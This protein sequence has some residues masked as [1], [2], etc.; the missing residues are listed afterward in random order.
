MWLIRKSF[1]LLCAFCAASLADDSTTKKKHSEAAATV[2]SAASATVWT[3]PTD[4]ESRNLLYG[5]GGKKRAPQGTMFTFEKEDLNGTNPKFDVRDDAGVKWKLKLG[6][7]AR[8]ETAATRL[9]WAV[10]YFTTDDYLVP[11]LRIAELPKHVHR[12]GDLIEAGGEVQ[13]AR[14]KRNPEGYDKAGVCNWTKHPT[15]ESR[16]YSGLKVMMA[17]LNNWDLKD[18]NNALFERKQH[19]DGAPDQ[20]CLVTDLGATFG[21]TGLGLNHVERKGQLE[22]YRKSKFITKATSEYVD[23]A[24]PSRPALFILFNPHEYFM[25]VHLDWIG[26]HIPR[27]DVQWVAG[28]L[29]R[30]SDAQIR[31]AFRAGGFSADEVDGFATV[32]E[33][34]IAALKNL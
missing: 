7:E 8:P 30:L 1:V 25:R 14:L 9:V 27:A 10:G 28:I 34:R 13:N 6:S 18:E 21:V 3:D 31:D 29:A 22:W 23:F 17:L 19:R 20:I 26:H 24:T 33:Q 2:E 16:E 4:L 11:K 5:S 12:G 32:V 15:V